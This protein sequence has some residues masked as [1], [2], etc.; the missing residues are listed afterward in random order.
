MIVSSSPGAGP[1]DAPR[2]MKG[3]AHL[4]KGLGCPVCGS[5]DQTHTARLAKLEATSARDIPRHM[6]AT[7]DPR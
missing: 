7:D 4:G 6:L 5:H 2:G 1:K 3:H